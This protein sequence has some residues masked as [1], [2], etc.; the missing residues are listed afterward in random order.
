MNKYK[1]N[2]IFKY[3]FFISLWFLLLLIIFLFTLPKHLYKN[4]P[5]DAEVMVVEGWLPQIAI[6]KAIAEYY[7]GNYK[8]MA[9]TGGP[10]PVQV[11]MGYYGTLVFNTGYLTGEHGNK[12]I[13]A[14]KV[15]AHGTKAD[16]SY[17]CLNLLLNDSLLGKYFVRRKKNEYEFYINKRLNDI[18]TVKINFPND[19]YT[20]WRDRNLYIEYIVIGD[21]KIPA[22]SVHAF[23]DIDYYEG[24]DEYRPGYINYAE[25]SAFILKYLG[26]KDSIV[27]L[28]SQIVKFSRTYSS[29][30]TFRRWY[31]NSPFK[32]K[33]VNIVSLGPHS[34]RTWMIYKRVLGKNTDV[35]IIMVNNRRYNRKN[36]WKSPEGIKDTIH[37]MASYIYTLFVWPF[38]NKEPEEQ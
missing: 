6:D 29:A 11:E 36:W 24:F 1:N 22:R 13:T 26:F 3:I 7:S 17:P 33:P 8:L 19:I 16:G 34:R 21:I 30:L 15:Y 14:I 32:G 27:A 2:S 4:K 12:E 37:E 20:R 23:Y 5:E 10:L 31:L 18:H 38:L 28:P 25:Y 35:G 9:T